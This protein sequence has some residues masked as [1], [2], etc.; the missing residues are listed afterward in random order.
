[1]GCLWSQQHK[2]RSGQLAESRVLRNSFAVLHPQEDQ[3]L[4]GLS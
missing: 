3:S 2:D 1:M 4:A